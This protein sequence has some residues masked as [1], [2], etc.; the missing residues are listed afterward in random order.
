MPSAPKRPCTY[1]GC[2]E[3]TLNGRCEKHK[4]Q[5][6]K[7]IDRQRGNANARG[8]DYRWQL[9]RSSFLNKHPLCTECHRNGM[10]VAAAVVDHI[11]PHRGD[12]KLFWDVGNWQSLCEMHHDSKTMREKNIGGVVKTKN[13]LVPRPGPPAIASFRF[14]DDS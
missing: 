1:P 13:G 6:L 3:L 14:G 9:A 4:R 8:Y 7:D 2:P 11:T 12:R 10:V 5:E